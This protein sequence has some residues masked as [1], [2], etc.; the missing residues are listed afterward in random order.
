MTH[1]G[2]MLERELGEPDVPDA[3]R[4]LP[5]DISGVISEMGGRRAVVAA[6]QRAAQA[7]ANHRTLVQRVYRWDRGRSRPNPSNANELRKALNKDRARR[8]REARRDADTRGDLR[9][10]GAIVDVEG[11]LTISDDTRL[12]RIHGTELPPGVMRRVVSLANAGDPDRAAQYLWNAWSAAYG[13]SLLPA[14]DR[15][16]ELTGGALSIGDS[17]GSVDLLGIEPA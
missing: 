8:R 4:R 3:A 11:T 16:A 12:R 9:R 17:A 7:G 14:Y 5:S 1:L 10:R 6:L 15:T 2:D 13:A